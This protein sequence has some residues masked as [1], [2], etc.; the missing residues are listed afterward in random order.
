MAGSS[1]DC[2]P[3][4]NVY[5]AQF[6][7]VYTN[8]CCRLTNEIF[9]LKCNTVKIHK[10][11]GFKLRGEWGLGQA[12]MSLHSVCASREACACVKGKSVSVTIGACA[13]GSKGAERET[14]HWKSPQ[15]LDK[16]A[17][18]KYS[19]KIYFSSYSQ[20]F[21]RFVYSTFSS[22]FIHTRDRLRISM[23]VHVTH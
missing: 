11:L 5:S 20:L 13:Q 19:P 2:E 12:T 15:Q 17:C 1:K 18:F 9:N 4:K 6:A 8:P 22:L 14:L 7:T 21:F 23:F 3:G 10:V 16:H